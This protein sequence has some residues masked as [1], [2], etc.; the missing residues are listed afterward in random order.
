MKVL[1]K[2][3]QGR[4]TEQGNDKLGRWTYVK[5]AT[6]DKNMIYV[7][8]IYKPCKNTTTKAGP[9]TVFQQQ[10]T[11]LRTNGQTIPNPRK[12]FDKDLLQFLRKIQEQEDRIILVGDFNEKKEK[13]PLF[14]SLYRMGLRDAIADHHQQLPS[15]RTCT[16]GNNVIDYCMCSISI[17]PHITRSTYEPFQLRTNSDHRGMVIDF[18]SR[19]LFGRR[20]HIAKTTDRGIQSSDSINVEKFFTHLTKLWKE[21]DITNKLEQATKSTDNKQ[22]LQ[23]KLNEVDSAVTKAILTAEKKTKRRERPPWSPALKQ[24]SLQVR[25]YKL[26]L[27]QLQTTNNMSEAISHTIASMDTND[28]IHEPSTKEEC[29][30]YLRR[31]Q[32]RLKKIRRNAQEKRKE[33]LDMLVQK[34]NLSNDQDKARI[35]KRI[36]KAEATKRCYKKLRWILNPPKPGVIF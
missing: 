36:Q 26:Y 17:L 35:I 16:K 27:N 31:A 21:Y 30:R 7:I 19:T 25:F 4:I 18:N 34:Y 24:A 22:T 6:K 20:D 13:S 1:D 32:K 28:P 10:W 29:Q 12:Q 9:S 15:F 5:L 14:Q 33:H 2:S 8:T 11:I 23:L 3:I